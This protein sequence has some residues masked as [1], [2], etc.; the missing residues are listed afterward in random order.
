[1][2][3]LKPELHPTISS[4]MTMFMQDNLVLLIITHKECRLHDRAHGWNSK[5]NIS[6]HKPFCQRVCTTMLSFITEVCTTSQN[7]QCKLHIMITAKCANF[8]TTTQ[9]N[10]NKQT[11]D[12][13][14]LYLWCSLVC[15]MA[16]MS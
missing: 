8:P 16:E 3:K 15:L 7:G 12:N 6:F 14:C 4:N 2:L 1:M 9:N 5:Y 10:N 13:I 11:T